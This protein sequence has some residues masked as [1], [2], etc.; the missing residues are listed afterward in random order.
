MQ[1]VLFGIAAIFAL[2]LL[3]GYQTRRA[4]IVCWFF[5]LSVRNRNTLIWADALLSDVLFWGMF[6]PW[7][8]WQSTLAADS[9]VFSP[10]R[11]VALG[12]LATA[13][14]VL[15]LRAYILEVER[16]RVLR[17]APVRRK[18]ERTCESERRVSAS[19]WVNLYARLTDRQQAVSDS[20]GAREAL[21]I[22]IDTSLPAGRVIRMMEQP[23]SWRGLPKAL[24]LD[25]GPEF[26]AGSL[27]LLF[28]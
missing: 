16:T 27:W 22:E 17:R 13:V 8:A 7:A 26:L 12:P 25:N 28:G 20:Q 11:F 15:K 4:T 9:W 14:T 10:A 21:A 1:A 18:G 6:L 19:V 2:L 24:R 3:V 5:L 23:K